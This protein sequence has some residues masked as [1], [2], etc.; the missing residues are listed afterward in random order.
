MEVPIVETIAQRVFQVDSDARRGLLQHLIE[1]EKWAQV[2]IFVATKVKARNL[3]GKLRIAG[4]TAGELHGDLEQD[5]RIDALRRFKSGKY[6]VLVA[7]DVAA[8]GIDIEKLDCVVNFDLPRSP[9]DYIHRIGRT[10]R[11]GEVGVAISFV[12]HET[13]AQFR[14]IEKRSGVWLEREQIAGFEL[15]GEAPKKS[16]GPAPVKGKR[17]SKKD[18]LR[19]LARKNG[20]SQHTQ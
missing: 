18:K 20:G 19:E 8:R 15:T 5:E 3:A 14:L 12:D 17:R 11:A 6:Q 10:G 13:E 4:F 7:T 1:L 16:K 2:L 9:D